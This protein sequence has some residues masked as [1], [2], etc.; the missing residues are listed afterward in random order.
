[1][2]K[3]CPEVS[4]VPFS[5]S[6]KEETYLVLLPN[7][8]SLQTTRGLYELITLLDG[9]RRVDEI[10]LLLSSR[11]KR[12][13]RPEEV[14]HWI[15]RH[16]LPHGL[17]IPDPDQP[18]SIH[19]DSGTP[20][21]TKGILLI[22]VNLLRPLTRHLCVLFHP[23][24]SVPL[25]WA[26]AICHA[27]VYVNLPCVTSTEFLTSIPPSTYLSGYLLV[28]LSVLFHEFGHLSA[29]QY[30]GCPHG[31]IRLGLYLVF[32]VFYAN[33][34]PAWQLERKAR[35]VVDLGGMYFQLMLTIPAFLLFHLTQE[36]VWLLLFLELD[37]M[38]LFCLNPFLRFDGY[39]LC[40]DILGVPN[41]RSRSRFLM[42]ILYSRLTRES[43]VPS[44][45]LLEL[46]SSAL[47]G[48]VLYALGTY[49]FGSLVLVLFFRFLAPRIQALPSE[50]TRLIGYALEDWLQGNTAGMAVRLV[51]LTFLVVMVLGA[52][53]LLK[54]ALPSAARTSTYL[55]RR[56]WG[57]G[58][59]ESGQG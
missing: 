21:P 15:D 14:R 3:L 4:I 7:G 46:R 53:R 40:S 55:L 36:Q 31:E 20:P 9:S 56:I 28:F 52:G 37:A 35:V 54:Q 51:Q 5:S 50:V 47:L 57:V 25:L 48:V 39:W 32:P 29:C 33:V 6:A 23:L 19:A 27:L 58:R 26:S 13:I 43:V 44:A 10:A 59:K 11:W 18:P 24:F 45:P 2:P 8:R 41:L 1:L 22:H 38:I 42:K 12:S 49:L 30:F 16:I 17:L 34:T